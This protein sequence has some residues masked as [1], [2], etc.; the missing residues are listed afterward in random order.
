MIVLASDFDNTLYFQNR[1]NG[2]KKQDIQSIKQWQRQGN[3][4]GICSGRPIAGLIHQL[5]KDLQPDFYI[6]STGGLI[7]DQNY[8]I[9]YGQTVP[10]DIAN[11]IYETYKNEI[12]LLPQTSSLDYVYITHPDKND[13]HTVKISS[14]K[15]M[16]GKELYSFS[17][18][19][20]TNSR[21]KQI[22]QEINEKYD[23]VDAYQNRDSV[24]IVAKG[25][26]KGKAIV[27]LKELL[28]IKRIA[29][30][31][32]SYNDLPMLEKVD[33]AFTFH[34]SP[35]EIQSQVDYVV[36]NIQ[37]AIDILKEE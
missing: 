16:R 25:C 7:L 36:F 33:T 5:P 19:K 18:I 26:S 2:Y 37:E 13:K 4:F 6:A 12:E 31:G 29:G 15:D 23:C 32:D 30:I 34:D 10:F 20:S 21:A 14:M 11:E 27:L 17:L 1:V 8:Q 28:D 24:D 3:L 35:Q 9:L 22:T